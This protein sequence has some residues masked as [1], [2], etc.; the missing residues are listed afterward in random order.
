MF[1]KLLK[2][3][4]KA[5]AK[6]MLLMYAGFLIFCVI[7]LILYAVSK[8]SNAY[9]VLSGLL[10]VANIIQISVLPLISYGIIIFFLYSTTF[11]AQGY[12]TFTL[13]VKTS[14][15]LWSKVI[16]S[17]VYMLI[18][19]IV[20]SLYSLLLTTIDPIFMQMRN[21]ISI[22]IAMTDFPLGFLLTSTILSLILGIFSVYLPMALGQLF[23]KHKIVASIVSY[24][25]IY[26]VE[27]IIGAV[28]L[29][30]MIMY[31]ADNVPSSYY[32][33]THI[34]TFN[35]TIYLLAILSTLL[36]IGIKGFFTFYICKKKINFD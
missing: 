5:L 23:N 7:E 6:Y 18:N 16:V 9:P 29:F 22:G 32:M 19:L 14:H 21:D 30:G 24:I 25:G 4:F 20:I 15:I 1:A 27:Q 17:F 35:N 34:T 12:L 2:H 33:Q 36:F 3:D 26:T 28:V 13:P 11:G 31:F 10:F 8:Q